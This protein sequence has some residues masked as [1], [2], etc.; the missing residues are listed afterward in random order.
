MRDS[1]LTISCHD[2]ISEIPTP[3][4]HGKMLEIPVWYIVACD[5]FP[6]GAWKQSPTPKMIKFHQ[7]KNSSKPRMVFW[8][9][10]SEPGSA[11]FGTPTSHV[12]LNDRIGSLDF[13]NCFLAFWSCVDS[14]NTCEHIV[15]SHSDTSPNY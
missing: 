7:D 8:S 2:C 1:K 11:N 12:A 5:V 10:F 3:T 15:G 6:T 13:S 4:F 9:V 14:G